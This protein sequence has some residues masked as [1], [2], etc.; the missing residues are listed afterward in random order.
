[1]NE[2]TDSEVVAVYLR[3]I[4]DNYPRLSVEKIADQL[5]LTAA[6]LDADEKD[7]IDIVDAAKR[8]N[9]H[10]IINESGGT[11]DRLCDCGGMSQREHY[12]V[13]L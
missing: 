1:M 3:Y 10:V 9:R 13:S 12:P 5:D 4:R 8:K 11:P 7:V 6:R 2:I